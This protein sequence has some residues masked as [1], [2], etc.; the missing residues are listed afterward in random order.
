MLEQEKAKSEGV[1]QAIK[2]FVGDITLEN[3]LDLYNAAETMF[4]D[5]KQYGIPFNSELERRFSG[6]FEEKAKDILQ[7]SAKYNKP[8][9]KALIPDFYEFSDNSLAKLNGFLSDLEE[10][11]RLAV[12]EE[13]KAK[14]DLLKLGVSEKFGEWNEAAF[15]ALLALH[16]MI[17][18]SEDET[19]AQTNN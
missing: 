12:K 2:G 14:Q 6:G 5:F 15:N 1:L 11:E 7:W 18:P 4:S 3:L 9:S 8:L 16:N 17:A 10:I 19:N 13:S